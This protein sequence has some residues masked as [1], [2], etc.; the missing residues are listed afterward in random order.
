[1]LVSVQANVVCTVEDAFHLLS[2]ARQEVEATKSPE[3]W[4]DFYP[5]TPTA[6]L[7]LLIRQ[8][9]AQRLL[10]CGGVVLHEIGH[11]ISSL[12]MPLEP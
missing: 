3:D 5:D 12:E 1:M 9:I 7:Q 10:T 11:Q 6:A 2:L 8:A 4:D